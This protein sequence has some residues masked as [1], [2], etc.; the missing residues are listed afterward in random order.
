MEKIWR[1]YIPVYPNTITKMQYEST[2]RLNSIGT[3]PLP[4][5]CGIPC[6][7]IMHKKIQ[8]QTK[9]ELIL[10]HLFEFAPLKD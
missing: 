10:H 4:Y 7:A 2:S 8:S 5:K 3:V 1:L 9:I 6:C